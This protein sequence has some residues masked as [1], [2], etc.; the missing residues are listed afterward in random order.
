MDGLKFSEKVIATMLHRNNPE[1][2]SLSICRGA[3]E[4]NS[5]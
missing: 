5:P 1:D 4:P 2:G 3:V